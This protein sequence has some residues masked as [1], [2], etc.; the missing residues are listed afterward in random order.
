MAFSRLCFAAFGAV[1]IGGGVRLLALVSERGGFCVTSCNGAGC[2]TFIGDGAGLCGASI[3][4]G[5]GFCVTYIAG[6][7]F[8]LRNFDW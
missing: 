7:A 1:F 5:A 4:G 8:F 3:G 6:G 2:V